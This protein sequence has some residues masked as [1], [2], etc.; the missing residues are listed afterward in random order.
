MRGPCCS[1]MCR[2]PS[3]CRPKVF[4]QLKYSHIVLGSRLGWRLFG[5]AMVWVSAVEADQVELGESA[6]INTDSY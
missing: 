4:E 6:N 2:R 1:L 3:D 5:F